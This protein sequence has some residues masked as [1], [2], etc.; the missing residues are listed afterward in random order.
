MVRMT[1]NPH[2]EEGFFQ[3]AGLFYQIRIDLMDSLG[4]LGF[5]VDNKFTQRFR[6][7]INAL[8]TLTY[9]ILHEIVSAKREGEKT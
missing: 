6:H 8:Y 1:R 2:I 7:E 4:N 3:H 9:A 5:E